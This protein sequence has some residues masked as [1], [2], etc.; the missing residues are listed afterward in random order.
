MSVNSNE[1]SDYDDGG[2]FILEP[3]F[4]KTIKFSFL[5]SCQIVSTI[6]SLV[7]F[8]YSI[9]LP[10]IYKKQ[11]N[12]VIICLLVANFLIT[13]TEL[14][15]TL[16][17]IYFGQVIP[18]SASLCL[19]WIFMNY[20]LF[21]TS[22][23]IMAIASFQR[24]LF[25]FHKQ[26]INT[27]L[28]H[29]LPIILPPI[30]LFIW[31]TS[32][33][34]FYPC[35]QFFDYT[36]LW[37]IGACYVYEGT[38][39]TIDWMLSS[40]TPV[41]LTIIFNIVLFIR[42]VHQKFKMRRGRTWRTTRK[43]ALQIFLISFLFLIIY[44]PLTIFGLIRLWFDPLFLLVLTMVY[45]AY[46][47]YLV[48]LLMPFICLISMPEIKIR[49]KRLFCRGTRVQTILNQQILMTYITRRNVPTHH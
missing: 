1:T 29:Y 23:W 18:S 35:Q 12:H 19:Y 44:L 30:L 21:T 7:L 24:Y 42:V 38:I 11:H 40:F 5:L 31:Y 3:S 22:G 32:L 13:T 46:A 14:P 27:R 26:L 4:S 8:Y 16:I 9:R 33:I 48:P 17:Y 15:L 28:K 20:L 37:C 41:V 39:G 36:Q 10:E 25:I 6:C 49:I 43:L 34:F 2:Y 47:I 45:F